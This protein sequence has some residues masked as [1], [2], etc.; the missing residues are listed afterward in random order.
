VVIPVLDEAE[1]LAELHRRLTTALERSGRS[2]EIVFVDDGSTDGTPEILRCL[3]GRDA[4]VHV[5]RLARNFGQHAALMAGLRHA[6][7]G[8]VV[9]M[10]A[11]MQTPP[12]EIEKLLAKLDEG[13]EVVFGVFGRRQHPP[14]QRLTSAVGHLLVECALRLPRGVHF[15]PF[16]ALNRELINRMTAFTGTPVQLE[17]LMRRCTDRMGAVPV[18]HEPRRAGATKYT[19]GRRLRFT[20]NLARGMTQTATALR[21]TQPPQ[22]VV[23]ECFGHGD[24]AS[25]GVV[26]A[27]SPQAAAPR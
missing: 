19:L 11:D 3:A 24:C 20:L 6:Q 13:F 2:F 10:D 4:R 15:S 1:N 7:G 27:E 8:T 22:Y 25:G 21:A 26:A 18:R 5:I 14:L 9:T 12:E 23:A 16:R 17:T